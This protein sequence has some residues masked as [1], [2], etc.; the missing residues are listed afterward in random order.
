MKTIPLTRGKVAMVSDE[1]F[2]KI[3]M[4]KWT[5]HNPNKHG[6]YA[7]RRVNKKMTLM[8]RVILGITD[9]S[10]HG[11]H[12]DGNGLNNVPENLRIATQSQNR[13]NMR[14]LRPHT[15][16]FKGVCKVGRRWRAHTKHGK[17]VHL[18][19]FSTEEEAAKAYDAYAKDHFGRFA[20]PNFP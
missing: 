3:G 12:I 15:S 14:N 17:N 5:A 19:Y 11:D 9:P 1:W 7:V 4:Y 6:W 20:H 2:E 8:H 18:G 13:M 10:I 16:K